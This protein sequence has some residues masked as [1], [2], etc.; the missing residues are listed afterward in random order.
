[1]GIKNNLTFIVVTYESDDVINDCLSSI[2][3]NYPTIVIENSGKK[4]FQKEIENK[5]P[6]VKCEIMKKNEGY[7]IGNN[8]GIKLSA[9][10]FV[11]ILNPDTRLKDNALDELDK[12][13]NEIKHFAILA[14]TLIRSDSKIGFGLTTNYG[15]YKKT[16]ATTSD[17]FEVDYI[18][19]CGLLLDKNELKNIG[20][21]D[22][23]IFMFFDDP[24]CSSAP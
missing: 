8:H 7:C 20:F 21:F 13:S 11:F 5:Y 22:E 6:N 24:K 16:L 19:G 12:V 18:Q 17:F 14:P 2:P 4:N 1:M 10:R 15:S 9:T 3:S 23:N